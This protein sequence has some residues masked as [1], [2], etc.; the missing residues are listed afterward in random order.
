MLKTEIILLLRRSHEWLYPIAFFV[1]VTSLFPLAFSPDPAFLKIYA[2]GCC[3][4][5]ALFASILSIQTIFLSDMEEGYLERLL[6]SDI[7]LTLSISTKLFAQWL[8]TSLPLVL[9]TPLLGAFFHL[10]FTTISTLMISLLLGTPILTLIGSLGVAL[11]LGLRQQGVLL[12][13]LVL[14]L[15]TPILI[16]G[17]MITQQ[18][19]AGFSILAPLC[20]LAGLCVLAISLLPFA[21]AATLRV[22][23]ND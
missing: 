23:L 22:S 3:W 13:L 11:T 9:L 10:S 14:P 21:I 19:Q 7:P 12:S 4:I 8:V 15:I 5:A 18:A 1:M 17:V 2:P 6:L 16:F 20:F